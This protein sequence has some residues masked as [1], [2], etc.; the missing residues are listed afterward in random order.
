[1][2]L[3]ACCA[4]GVGCGWYGVFGGVRASACGMVWPNEMERTV[5]VGGICLGERSL[6]LSVVESEM[7][8]EAMAEKGTV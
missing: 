5:F 3:V 1:M 4:Y 6:L 8:N 2:G 7:R